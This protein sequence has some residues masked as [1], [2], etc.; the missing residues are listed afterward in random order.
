MSK[1]GRVLQTSRRLDCSA[2]VIETAIK[3]CAHSTLGNQCK[4]CC[5]EGWTTESHLDIDQVNQ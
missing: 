3:G 5:L 1:Y 2:A 4:G